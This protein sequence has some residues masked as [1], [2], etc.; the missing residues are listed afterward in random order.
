VSGGVDPRTPVL[1][2]VGLGQRPPDG[3]GDVTPLELMVEAAR[4]AAADAGVPGLLRRVDTVAVTVGN[5]DLPDPGR[6][7]AARIG[8]DPSTT[9]RADVGVLQQ[10][11]VSEALARVRSGAADVVLVAGGEAMASNRAA[12][13]AGAEPR[14]DVASDPAWLPDEHWQHDG[15]TSGELVAEAEIDAGFWAPVE[16][17][18]CIELARS[19][20]LGW[21]REEHLDDVGRLWSAFDR[22]A[23]TNPHADFAGG[24][25]A[26]FLT[27]PS[28]ENRPMASPYTRW[29]VSQWSVDQAAALVVCS[30]GTAAALGVPRD[31][32]L[33]CRVALQ[34]SGAVPVSQRVALDRWPA[35]AV[36]GRAAEQHLGH[37]LADVEHV[38]CYSCFPVAVRVQQ[39]ELGLDPAGV[40]TLTGGMTFAGGPFNNS[41]YQF[42]RPLADRLR[43][44]PGSSGLL[45]TVSGLL[46]KPGLVV[47]S[48]RP[49]PPELVADLS[50]EA[51][52]ATA[53]VPSV[54]SADGPATVATATATYE[55]LD[56]VRAFVVADLPG[57]S[58]WIGTTEDADLVAATVA[59]TVVGT[60]VRVDGTSCRA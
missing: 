23:A 51:R 33:F 6:E 8:A 20:A 28:A 21:T 18:A 26:E 17:Y 43:A 48:A 53:T 39:R 52:R 16:H 40:P 44:D 4:A 15:S 22:I 56:P 32:W 42:T 11:P 2:G 1:V 9:I 58:R 5:W 10:T 47:W 38:E 24:R 12:A 3:S 14:V 25:S 36:L 27:T 60:P 57:G 7:L 35:M 49:G 19:S 29:L 41:T 31:R 34:S 13:R 59:G 30:A 55:G 37:P 45:T 46:T 54:A 50:D